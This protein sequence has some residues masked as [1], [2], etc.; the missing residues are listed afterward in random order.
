MYN[1]EKIE[2]RMQMERNGRNIHKR[3]G[4]RVNVHETWLKLCGMGK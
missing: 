2:L 3:E 1:Y 4:R